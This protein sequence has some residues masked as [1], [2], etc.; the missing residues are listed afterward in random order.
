[1]LDVAMKDADAMRPVEPLG[2]RLENAP[3]AALVEP[4]PLLEHSRE[5]DSVLEVHD[6][7]SG[8]VDLEQAA[9]ADDVRMTRGGRQ[10]PQELGFFDKLLEA[11]RVDLFGVRV[12]RHDR[13]F[14]V[15]LADRAREIFLDG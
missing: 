11:E 4:P 13:V 2:D 6:H 14:A 12:D 3:Q 7:V 15:A 9:D 1:R 10:V 8:A 5:R